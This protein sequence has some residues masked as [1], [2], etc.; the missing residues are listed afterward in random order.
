MH[1]IKTIRDNPAA[2]DHALSLRGLPAQSAE[3][4]KIDSEKR[5]HI[6]KLQDAQARRNAL[7][8]EIGEVMRA[9]DKA[10]AETLKAE[11]AGLKDFMR[12]RG[13]PAGSDS[14]LMEFPSFQTSLDGVPE[15]G[16]HETRSYTPGGKAQVS[17][18]RPAF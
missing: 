6:Q 16:E 4:L 11:V 18:S 5:D 7:S 9:G 10:K 3:L 2:F 13:R 14:K 8:K 1:D 17:S 15:E 12:W